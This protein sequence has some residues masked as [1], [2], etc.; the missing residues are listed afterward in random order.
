[1]LLWLAALAVRFASADEIKTI[2]EVGPHYR[3]LSFEKNEN[4]QNIMEIYTKLDADCHLVADSKNPK[5]P[6]FGFYWLMDGA[7]F[8]P[9]H[10]LIRRGI[11]KRM[12]LE[13]AQGQ[14][15]GSSF[16]VR[17][18]DLKELE[19]DIKE[20]RMTITAKRRASGGCAVEAVMTLGPSDKDAQVVLGSIYSEAEKSIWPPFRRVTSVELRGVNVASGTPLKRRY[21]AKP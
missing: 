8:K 19:S 14:V 20:P 5:V 7:R 3:I 6:V 1:M 2:P 15:G 13:V 12:Q 4:P 17:L 10:P 16:K 9:V 18:A 11:E 21:R